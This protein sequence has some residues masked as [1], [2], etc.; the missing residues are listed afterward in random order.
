[1]AYDDVH[2]QVVMFGGKTAANAALADTWLWDG[3]TWTQVTPAHR[4]LA[5]YGAAMG[6]DEAHHQIVMFSG[7]SDGVVYSED[8]WIWDGDMRDWI[9]QAPVSSPERRAFAGLAWDQDRH[10]LVLYGGSDD[11][12]AG[13]ISDVWEWDG[14][15]WR[16]VPAQHGPARESAGVVSDL[17]GGILV[18]GG[19][20][21][22]SASASDP[23]RLRWDGLASYETCTTVD[24]DGDGLAGCADSDCAAAC[25]GCGDGVCDPVN[26]SCTSCPADCGACA[27]TCGDGVCGPSESCLADC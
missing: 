15:D 16:L 25:V 6:Y 14:A 27:P 9:K 5:T 8:T 12:V 21:N 1:M 11:A 4:P 13:A 7:H 20:Y 26:E 18:I 2:H 19:G 17:D 3:Q 24:I 10:R 22:G 23:L